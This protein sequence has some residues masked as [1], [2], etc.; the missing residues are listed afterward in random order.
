M[1]ELY[2]MPG[3]A[4]TVVMPHIKGHYYASHRTINPTGIV[5]V[6]PDLDFDAPHGRGNL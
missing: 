5:P 4:A 1:R 6:G 3:I 2:Q